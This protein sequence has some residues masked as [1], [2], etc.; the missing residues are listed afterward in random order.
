MTTPQTVFW[1]HEYFHVLEGMYLDPFGQSDI[2]DSYIEE[3]NAYKARTR[4][5]VVEGPLHVVRERLHDIE[6]KVVDIL[7][8]ILNDGAMPLDVAFCRLII[9]LPYVQPSVFV[10]VFVAFFFYF[11]V[12]SCFPSLRKHIKL[13]WDM[14]E[15]YEDSK[16]LQ[17]LMDSYFPNLNHS[18]CIKFKYY[19]NKSTHAISSVL[20]Q[21]I[22]TETEYGDPSI[23]S[24]ICNFVQYQN[25][26]FVHFICH[27]LSNFWFHS[28]VR[29]C[30]YQCINFVSKIDGA[31]HMDAHLLSRLL[32]SKRFIDHNDDRLKYEAHHMA[33]MTLSTGEEISHYFK[34]TTDKSIRCDI[35][36]HLFIELFEFSVSNPWRVMRDAIVNHSLVIFFGGNYEESVA[37]TNGFD[38]LLYKQMIANLHYVFKNIIHTIPIFDSNDMELSRKVYAQFKNCYEFFVRSSTECEEESFKNKLNDVL[39][40]YLIDDYFLPMIMM[41]DDMTSSPPPRKKRRLNGKEKKNIIK[42]AL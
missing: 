19:G 16:L 33:L 40:Q 12:G 6:Q 22:A 30:T 23:A 28:S 38:D 26:E 1:F 10:V 3:A 42:T 29:R 14:P 4:L 9:L 17:Y 7:D 24:I 15:E 27:F 18:Q 41:D 8:G 32:I 35:N 31:M 13:L 25:Q 2:I 36:P 34:H 11:I 37:P 20:E 21:Y 39:R 5:K